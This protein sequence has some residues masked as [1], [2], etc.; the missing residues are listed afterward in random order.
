MMEKGARE[1]SQAR[2]S[3]ILILNSVLNSLMDA[4]KGAHTS[5]LPNLTPCLYYHI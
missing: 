1:R 4:T 2:D 5:N 3:I